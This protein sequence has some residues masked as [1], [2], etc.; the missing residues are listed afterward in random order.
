MFTIP[1]FENMDSTTLRELHVAVTNAAKEPTKHLPN[2]DPRIKTLKGN[3]ARKYLMSIDPENWI[4]AETTMLMQHFEQNRTYGDPIK[5]PTDAEI[6]DP[7]WT[8]LIKLTVNIKLDKLVTVRGSYTKLE[9][10]IYF[11]PTH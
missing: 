4:N 11:T 6:I 10:N 5:S 3:R 2:N 9:R 7:V 8:H 1:E